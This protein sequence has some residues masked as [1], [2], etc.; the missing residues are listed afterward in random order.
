MRILLDTNVIIAALI[1]RGVCHELLEHCAR[2]HK[3]VT[4]DF[5]LDEVRDKLIQKFKYTSE[6][7]DEAVR[8]LRSRMEVVTP[9]SL[10]AQVCRDPDDDS[11]L[12]TAT[13][14]NCKFI[15]TGDKDLLV[16]QTFGEVKIVG[17]G[18]FQRLESN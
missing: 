4:S 13:A 7:A 1:A 2:R 8:L 12:A 17:P 6:V 9:A 14:G 18:D 15:I 10:D 5:I 3:L 11:I 16:L